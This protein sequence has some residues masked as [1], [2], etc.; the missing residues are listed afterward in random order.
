MVP[1]RSETARTSW[2]AGMDAGP[3]IRTS[4]GRSRNHP[5]SVPS[6][7]GRIFFIHMIPKNIKYFS[8]C[9]VSTG[10]SEFFT[11]YI[12]D[13]IWTGFDRF[14]NRPKSVPSWDSGKKIYARPK[15][16]K[17]FSWCFVSIAMSDF[18]HAGPILNRFRMVPGRVRDVWVLLGS[19]FFFF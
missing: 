14:R 12:Q 8:W 13:Q 10:M 9:Y 15:N 2:F 19:I 5:R 1:G 6:W 16:S 7:D 18:L 3:N 4:F 17:Y 11:Y